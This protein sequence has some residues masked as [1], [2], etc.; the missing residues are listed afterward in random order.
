MKTMMNL[1]APIQSCQKSRNCAETQFG[2]RRTVL[3]MCG[4]PRYA[5]KL[6]V[7]TPSVASSKP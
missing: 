6:R 1:C 3:E 7:S 4:W 5:C 2:E